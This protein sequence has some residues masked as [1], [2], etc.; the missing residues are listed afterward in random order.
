MRNQVLAATLLIGGCAS[1]PTVDYHLMA[2]GAYRDDAVP[3]RLTDSSIVIGT[4]SAMAATDDAGKLRVGPPI[5]FDSGSVSCTPGG[6][7][8]ISAM[9]APVEFAEATYALIPRSRRLIST[10]VTPVYYPNSLRLASLGIEV[11]DHRLEAINT[12][13]AIVGGFAKLAASADQASPPPP[14]AALELPIVIEFADARGRA[15]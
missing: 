14:F 2:V 13:G 6:C 12:V 8:G 3:F 11:K 7:P 15:R 1:A 10:I 9:T 5:S 4:T